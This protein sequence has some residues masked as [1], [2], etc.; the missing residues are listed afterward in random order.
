M[1]S[2]LAGLIREG[3]DSLVKQGFLN[4]KKE[5]QE[6]VLE[7]AIDEF[8]ENSY[9][10][11]SINRIIQKAGISKGSMYHYFENKEDLYM[12]MISRVMEKKAE[13]LRSSLY[14]T[15]QVHHEVNFFET[16]TSQLQSSI[17]FA[18]KNV[19][20]HKITIELHN[21]QDCELKR[22]IWERFSLT[23]EEYMEKIVDDAIDN[24]EIRSDFDK[25]FVLRV[26]QLILLKF[27]EL[28]PDYDELLEK[29]DQELCNDMVQL[30]AF[31]KSGLE[32]KEEIP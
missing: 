7:A 31:L 5:E 2:K 16:M 14:S 12:Y 11:A 3:G 18:K 25:S 4:L 27:T 15:S 23:F 9:E 24:G 26:L 29:K 10:V 13:Y 6:R 30:V 1:K 17:L 28:Y 32:K 20:Y 21:M 22:R 19:R 8:S